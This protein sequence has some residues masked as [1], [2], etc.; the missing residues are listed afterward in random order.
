M[1]STPPYSNPPEQNKQVELWKKYLAWEKSNPF[2]TE[3][4]LLLTNLASYFL[5]N[6]VFCSSTQV[7]SGYWIAIP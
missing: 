5:Q 6:S 2:R 3:D 4:Q 7:D 1:P